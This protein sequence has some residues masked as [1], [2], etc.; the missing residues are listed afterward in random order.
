MARRKKDLE[1]IDREAQRILND[2]VEKSGK[3]QAEIAEATGISQNRVSIILR[4][5]TPPATVG[6]IMAIAHVV[7]LSAA[8]IISQAEDALRPLATVTDLSDRSLRV[9]EERSAALDPGYPPEDE[10]DPN[11]P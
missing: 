4:Q 9:I 3:S 5:D 2:A 8:A 1:P 6:E 7:G 10:Q 11:T